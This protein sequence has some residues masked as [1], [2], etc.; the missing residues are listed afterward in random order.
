[1][2]HFKEWTNNFLETFEKEVEN[3]LAVKIIEK[4]GSI[5]AK[6]CGAISEVEKIIESIEDKN[7][8]D[9]I[10]KK[11]NES[12]IGGGNLIRK[13]K[14]IIGTYDECYC[15][16]RKLVKSNIYCN[17]TVGWAKEVFRKI[18]GDEI[19][20]ELVK[21]IYFGDNNCEYRIKF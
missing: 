4:N 7:N 14:V 11:L 17:C 5:C 16:T 2:E 20:V 9:T 1:M 21:S 19:E 10:I 15:P 18:L 12:R 3:K 8:I 6:D 13:G